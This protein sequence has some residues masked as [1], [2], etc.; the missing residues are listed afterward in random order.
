ME[1]L[2]LGRVIEF[3]HSIRVCK[4]NSNF[5]V[6]A[7]QGLDV[8]FDGVVE[9]GSGDGDSKDG[10]NGTEESRVGGG[11]RNV[12]SRDRGLDGEHDRLHRE[13]ETAAV[14]EQE[15]DDHTAGR[16]LLQEG[17]E[18]GTDG[19]KGKADP[20]EGAVLAPLGDHEARRD[21]GDQKTDNQGQHLKT[22]GGGRFLTNDLEVQGHEKHDTEETH[23]DKQRGRKDGR[24]GLVLEQAEGENG[25]N[26]DLGLDEAEDKENGEATAEETSNQRV[27]PFPGVASPVQGQEDEDKSDNQGDDS[28]KVNTGKFLA[29]RAL[30]VRQVKQLDNSDEGDGTDRQVNEEGPAP[31]GVIGEDTSK[32]GSKNR[33]EAKDGTDNTL[34]LATISK[35]DQV[36]DND[37][38]Q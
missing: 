10:A 36:S 19:R 28:I 11:D 5:G 24:V 13:T 4:D 1:N 32:K 8:G 15:A 2:G 25:L 18:T 9:D 6:H 35:R 7:E 29:E 30:G 16:V 17:Q 37:H 22:R 31:R 23:S 21:R 20:N 38:D 12:G 3:V 14:D 27:V 34:V 33:R 26:G